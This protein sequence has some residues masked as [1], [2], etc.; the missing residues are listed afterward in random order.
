MNDLSENGK[1][2]LRTHACWDVDRSAGL[3]L[4][5]HTIR[6]AGVINIA[7]FYSSLSL[8]AVAFG[9]VR[10]DLEVHVYVP[11]CTHTRTHVQTHTTHTH[12]HMHSKT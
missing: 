5:G 11:T 2:L 3:F 8:T 12:V 7:V 9:H 6:A 1:R 10:T 4:L